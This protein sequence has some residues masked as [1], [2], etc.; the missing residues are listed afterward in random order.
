VALSVR[1]Y[2]LFRKAED[3]GGLAPGKDDNEVEREIDRTDESVFK[4]FDYIAGKQ[5]E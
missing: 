5:E 2:F 4:W 1:G 3:A